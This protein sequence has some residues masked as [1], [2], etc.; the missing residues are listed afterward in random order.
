MRVWC[1]VSC[2]VAVVV[3]LLLS[4][5]ISLHACLSVQHGGIPRHLTYKDWHVADKLLEWISGKL[6]K[7]MQAVEVKIRKVTA[8]SSM[9]A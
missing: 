7:T 4:N 1:G 3:L 6:G 5:A 9:I 2:V 8:I